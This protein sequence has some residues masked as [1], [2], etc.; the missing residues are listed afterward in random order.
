MVQIIVNGQ[1]KE[2]PFGTT[3]QTVA[4]EYQQEYKDDIL[5]VQ[6]DG[7]LQELHKKVK[8]CKEIKFITAADS[9]VTHVFF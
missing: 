9:A 8:E 2:Y 4:Q 1:E 5:L 6:V 3:W 7:K